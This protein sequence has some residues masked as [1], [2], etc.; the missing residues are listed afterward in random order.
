VRESIMWLYVCVPAGLC[1]RACVG[2]PVWVWVCLCV[3]AQGAAV[4]KTSPT[5]GLQPVK[6]LGPQNNC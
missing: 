3:Q 1:V 5:K 6:I 2:V 4:C